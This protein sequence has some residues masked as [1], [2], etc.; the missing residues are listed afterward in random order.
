VTS[1]AE[2]PR[3][4]APVST[5]A[6]QLERRRDAATVA[7]GLTEEV[8]L[9]G[10]G[11]P[12]HVPGRGDTTY[13]FRVHPEY[14]YL[15]DRERP[16]GVLAFDPAAG[17]YDFVA[18]VTREEMLWS[19]AQPDEGEGI[20]LPE[21]QSWL[22]AREGRPIA[23][24][25]APQPGVISDSALVERVRYGLDDVRRPKDEVEL[26]RMRRA[27]AATR[28][29]FAA[30]QPMLTAGV[31]ERE[32]QIELEASFL[33]NGADGLGFNTIVA[34]GP[35]SAILHF[36]P[37]ERSLQRGELVLI[38]AGAEHRGY[39]SD[40]TRTYPVDRGFSAQQQELHT[41]VRAAG[42]AAIEACVPGTDFWDV[43]RAAALVIA[44]GLVELGLL[45][46]APE[47]LFER[48][49]VGLFYPHGVGHMVG[50][51]VRDVVSRTAK[52][53]ASNGE[54]SVLRVELSLRPGFV[55]T[56]EPGIYF[57]PALL[58]DEAARELHR[59]AVDWSR[60]DRMLGFGGIRIEDNVLITEAG[61]EV[62]TRDLPLLG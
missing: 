8:V 21:F 51:G 15:T 18:P 39:V 4:R 13:P 27:E 53:R 42:R 2:E 32:I 57:V 30:I 46:G 37:A 1:R 50:L 34:S 58:Q 60:A 12:I 9:I 35:N 41:L 14:F 55:M 25:G 56:I 16:G 61:P 44:A 5:I 49:S 3:S 6:E 11:A 29:G 59:D 24:L 45:R 62:L 47:S 48:G 26:D 43:H 31:T 33:R 52:R 28:A 10:A 17:W 20:P 36:P 40:V 38:D 22:A 19:G 23:G 7:W 54:R